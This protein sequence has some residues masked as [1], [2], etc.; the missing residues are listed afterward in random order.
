M[1]STF[2]LLKKKK[3]GRTRFFIFGK[4]GILIIKLVDIKLLKFFIKQ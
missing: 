2:I 1:E 3:S 4:W